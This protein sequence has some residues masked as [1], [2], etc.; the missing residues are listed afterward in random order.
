MSYSLYTD[1]QKGATTRLLVE[2]IFSDY[3]VRFVKTISF[4]SMNDNDDE[5]QI[6]FLKGLNQLDFFYNVAYNLVFFKI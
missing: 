3:S 4:N 2:D 1:M 5:I 6:M